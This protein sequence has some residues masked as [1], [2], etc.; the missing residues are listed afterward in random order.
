[1]S[2]KSGGRPSD[3]SVVT[4]SS[5]C[6]WWWRSPS[7]RSRP[8]SLRSG[9]RVSTRSRRRRLG[10]LHGRGSQRQPVGSDETVNI[11]N[12]RVNSLG[13]SGAE[14]QTSGKNQISVSIRASPTRAGPGPD[15]ADGSR[16]FRPVQCFAYPQGV[17]RDRRR[18]TCREGIESIPACTASLPL[19]QANLAVTPNNSPQGYSSNNVPPDS[20]YVEY[21]STSVDKPGYET[22]TC[23]CR[24]SPPAAAP[25][26]ESATSSAGADDR[27]LHRQRHRDPGPDR[28]VGGRLHPDR[29]GLV[30]V[31][32]GG[33][34]ELPPA[35]RHR[36]R[37][38]RLPGTHDPAH[39][40]QLHLL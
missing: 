3:D 13:V 16:V 4:S 36:A 6:W 37:R 12:L 38:C 27:S 20:Q 29:P 24:G 28:P 11:L 14:V 19:T 5:A 2:P 8:C 32:Q 22:S 7:D 25:T 15:R 23:C 35:A 34:G 17:P 39:P 18:T 9:R 31:G 1:M 40:E 21:P 30:P 33:A 10:R 26:A